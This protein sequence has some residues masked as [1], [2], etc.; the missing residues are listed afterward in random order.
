M[1]EARICRSC[2][3]GKAWNRR[4]G[5]G[6]FSPLLMPHSHEFFMSRAYILVTASI[7]VPKTKTAS[8]VTLKIRAKEF[9]NLRKIYTSAWGKILVLSLTFIQFKKC[10]NTSYLVVWVILPCL[11]L[12]IDISRDIMNPCFMF[13]LP[14][15]S[16]KTHMC[17]CKCWNYNSHCRWCQGW[18][19]G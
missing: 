14:E 16:M 6:L 2:L 18:M 19:H 3:L 13:W 1:T 12:N 10:F 15:K 9:R 5:Q 17:L 11:C 7:F 8:T 4:C